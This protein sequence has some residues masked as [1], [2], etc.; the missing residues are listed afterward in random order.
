MYVPVGQ[1]SGREVTP[2]MYQ[3]IYQ[4]LYKQG[5]WML[6]LLCV[7]VMVPATVLAQDVVS[8][9]SGAVQLDKFMTGLQSLQA[10]FTQTVKDS[11]NQL[12]EQS[13]GT[14]AIKKPGKF[15]WEYLKPNAQ[16]IVSD[17][18][19]IWLYDPELEQVTIRRA[20]LSLNGTPA[21]L[22]SGTGGS[23]R[24]SFEVEHVEQRDGMTVLNLAPK[25]TDTDFKLLQMALRKDELVAMSLTDKLGQTTLL[26]FRQF[27]RNAGV[28][29]AQFKFAAPKGVDVIDQSGAAAKGQ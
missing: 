25:R 2:A 1:I 23:W 8:A 17:G 21:A 20:E 24:D 10:S 16:T 4:H 19:R 27:K 13:S 11:R 22:L 5:M 6:T 18:A 12:V 14:L 3:A 28:T 29:E 9:E 7:W 26:E 15:R